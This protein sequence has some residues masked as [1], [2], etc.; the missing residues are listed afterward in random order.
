V[1]HIATSSL[2]SGY[3]PKHAG[4]DNSRLAFASSKAASAKIA[5]SAG[6]VH[7]KAVRGLGSDRV[8]SGHRETAVSG[9]NAPVRAIDALRKADS[10]AGAAKTEAFRVHTAAVHDRIFTA[11]HLTAHKA[12]AHLSGGKAAA[13]TEHSASPAHSLISVGEGTK[14]IIRDVTPTVGG[15]HFK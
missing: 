6:G 5:T 12:V 7:E 9:H 8:V 2:G 15:G 13:H 14:I 4:P 3:D 11:G 1:G 10:F